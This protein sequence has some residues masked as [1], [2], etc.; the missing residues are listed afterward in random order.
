MSGGQSPV[1]IINDWE[2]SGGLKLTAVD[3]KVAFDALMRIKDKGYT[4]RALDFA[5]GVVIWH[6]TLTEPKV[7]Q[8]HAHKYD[9]RALLNI[10]SELPNYSNIEIDKI[11]TY[12]ATNMALVDAF[13]L[14][15][16]KGR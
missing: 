9:A 4:I 6:S 12:N 10:A 7:M 5:P 11:G 2:E 13:G 1:K 15:D 8:F 14:H 16:K 3:E